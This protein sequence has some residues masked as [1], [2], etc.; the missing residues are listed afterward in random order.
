MTPA[1]PDASNCNLEIAKDKSSLGAIETN[2]LAASSGAE[3]RLVSPSF[4]LELAA[5]TAGGFA[6]L[7]V[8]HPF[9]T[10]KVKLQRGYGGGASA[11]T[12]VRRVVASEGF[13][14]LY[15]GMTAPLPFVV[16]LT[17][18]LF[19]TNSGIRSLFAD[20]R[21]DDELSLQEIAIAGAGAGV[22]ISAIVG[23]ME[24]VKCR[25]QAH[26]DRYRHAL[27]CARKIYAVG[28]SRAFITGLTATVVRE[29]PGTAIYFGVYEGLVRWFRRRRGA[30]ENTM[31]E[32]MLAGGLA[33]VGFWLPCYPIDYLK[34]LQQT[35]S[36]KKPKYK[37]LVHLTRD[38]VGQNGLRGLFRGVGPALAR[39]FPASAVTF[40]VYE[41][42]K[43]EL[44]S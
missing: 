2:N 5:G 4:L 18:A 40:L 3:T 13:A 1:V 30:S 23:P 21:R 44:G 6:Q 16:A 27:D 39:S 29:G 34:T 9:D 43:V 38:T 36:I 37:G 24:L 41:R 25:M 12:V 42:V 35:D 31:S 33:G 17:A 15:A 22:A 19:A 7:C 8:G 28:G 32:Q 10:T 14:G 20:G 11:M 26:P